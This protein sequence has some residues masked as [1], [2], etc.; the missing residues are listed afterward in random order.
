[1]RVGHV[2]AHLLAL[3]LL[4]DRRRG[5]RIGCP[6]CC[7]IRRTSSPAANCGGRGCPLRGGGGSRALLVGFTRLLLLPLAAVFAL[8]SRCG[9]GRS[10]GSNALQRRT[11]TDKVHDQ[12]KMFA[13]AGESA[14]ANLGYERNAA[15]LSISLK[16][17]R[18][19]T[20]VM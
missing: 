1:M 10:I 3:H 15:H 16:R 11:R 6:S 8:C 17:L 18:G 20:T 5:Q 19:L 4:L 2:L 9:G 13:I 14:E 7:G 12:R